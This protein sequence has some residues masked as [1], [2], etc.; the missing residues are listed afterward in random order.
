MFRRSWRTQHIFA[1][2]A[3]DGLREVRIVET[4]SVIK[5]NRR[6][7]KIDSGRRRVKKMKW[8]RL[9]RRSRKVRTRRNTR[10]AGISGINTRRKNLLKLRL[11]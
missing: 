1:K 11:N 5:G 8:K 10:R 6:E 2:T 9:N 4:N 3:P 7:G